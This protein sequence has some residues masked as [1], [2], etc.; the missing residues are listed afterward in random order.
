MARS[1]KCVR[2]SELIAHVDARRA[3]FLTAISIGTSIWSRAVLQHV[4]PLGEDDIIWYVLPFCERGVS[5][6]TSVRQSRIFSVHG[7]RSHL[8]G[9]VAVLV[10]ESAAVPASATEHTIARGESLSLDASL[11][12]HGAAPTVDGRSYGLSTVTTTFWCSAWLWCPVRRFSRIK[13]PSR[14]RY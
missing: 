9:Y 7:D 3:T 2:S 5:A 4:E 11:E 10:A 14:P 1:F 8:T 12:P 13:C 6:P